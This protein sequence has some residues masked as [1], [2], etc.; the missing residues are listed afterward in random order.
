MN[1]DIGELLKRFKVSDPF[2]LGAIVGL[3]ISLVLAI[4]MGRSLLTTLVERSDLSAELDTTNAAI[5]QI[6][7]MQQQSP[8]TL[9]QG[10]AK[11]QADLDLLLAGYPTT[12]QSSAELVNYYAYASALN[13]QLRSMEKVI[14][15]AE[16]QA[17]SAYTRDQFL[18]EVHGEVPNLLRFLAKIGGGPYRSFILDNVAIG[19]DSPAIADVDLS[20]YGSD[21]GAGAAPITPTLTV[22]PTSASS[23]VVL[24]NATVGAPDVAQLRA[25]Q[26]IAVR[27]QNWP[28]AV[29]TGRQLRKAGQEGEADRLALYQAHVAWGQALLA[30]G[31]RAEARTQFE[32]AL[33][34]DPQALEAQ[35]GLALLDATVIEAPTATPT[36]MALVAEGTVV[37]P[38]AEPVATAA[39]RVHLVRSGESLILLANRY[40][41]TVTA[42]KQANGLR[43]NVIYI[44]QKL[45]IPVAQGDE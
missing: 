35:A 36:A 43:S 23:G 19:P 40:H 33:E 27:D 28:L 8:E 10:L 30:R 5:D 7:A 20:I 1:Q 37:P 13:C 24:P 31:E 12:V 14:P 6:T 15:A 44:G 9:R 21:Y 41:T 39:P 26:A 11:V 2:T 34:L 22:T 4:I 17:E 42:L 45:I 3:V 32:A 38:L 18:I 16:E 29:A 25:L